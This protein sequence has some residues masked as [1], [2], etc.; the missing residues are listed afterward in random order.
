MTKAAK[1]NKSKIKTGPFDSLR[2]YM[3]AIEAHGNVIRIDEIDQFMKNLIKLSD[4][5]VPR[6]I[7]PSIL[8]TFYS[9]WHFTTTQQHQLRKIIRRWLVLEKEDDLSAM[10]PIDCPNAKQ[11]ITTLEHKLNARSLVLHPDNN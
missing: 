6:L 10:I 11:A 9:R 8:E 1:G 3:D 7:E 4:L 2:D 5:A